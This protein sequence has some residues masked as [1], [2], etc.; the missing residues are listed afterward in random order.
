MD[1]ILQLLISISFTLP[2][3]LIFSLGIILSLINRKTMRKAATFALIG[4]TLLLINSFIDIIHVS[5]IVLYASQSTTEFIH[6][7]MTVKGIAG[8]IFGIA[9]FI[10]LLAAIF[11][12]RDYSNKTQT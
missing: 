9:G 3:L 2:F 6:I 11:V 7:I 4:F 12:K 1:I 8:T 5:W 10:F